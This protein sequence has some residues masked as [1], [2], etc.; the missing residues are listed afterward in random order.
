MTV[1]FCGDD[2]ALPR[3]WFTAQR[4]RGCCGGAKGK[5]VGDGCHVP[6]SRGPGQGRL[7]EITNAQGEE[8]VLSIT[9]VTLT[10]TVLAE[11][12]GG[13][14]APE[15]CLSALDATLLRVDTK[16]SV[17][18]QHCSQSV[19]KCLCVSGKNMLW[20]DVD[21]AGKRW[22]NV[23]WA[24]IGRS[25]TRML[26]CCEDFDGQSVM[27]A[28]WMRSLAW[29]AL[30]EESLRGWLDCFERSRVVTRVVAVNSGGAHGETVM[31]G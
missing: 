16:N 10:S 3:C 27:G 23:Q 14:S 9:V 11:S 1:T 21:G 4:R 6:C 28:L 18:C 29:N 22:V 13:R 30:G 2:G 7:L 17:V 20:V 24:D 19:D 31:A 25:A 15:R 26:R 12:M 5:G 8:T